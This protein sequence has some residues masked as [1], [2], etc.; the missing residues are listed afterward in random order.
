MELAK[1]LMETM[2]LRLFFFFFGYDLHV[3]HIQNLCE[4]K[5]IQIPLFDLISL[6]FL[7]YF[8][9]ERREI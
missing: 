4:W 2:G 6:V 7:L 1:R 9:F 5:E 8:C 3:L